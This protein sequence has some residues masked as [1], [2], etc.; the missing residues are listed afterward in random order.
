MRS[1]TASRRENVS[2]SLCLELSPI[3]LVPLLSSKMIV[4]I[5]MMMTMIIMVIM[6]VLMMM[7]N[8]CQSYFSPSELG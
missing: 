6:I 3:G 8:L 1:S 7:N 5:V 4:V 2:M